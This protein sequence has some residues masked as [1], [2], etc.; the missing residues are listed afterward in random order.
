M[1]AYFSDFNISKEHAL[2]NFYGGILTSINMHLYYYMYVHII[3]QIQLL[4]HSFH[5]YIQGKLSYCHG[6][7]FNSLKTKWRNLTE[8]YT[9]VTKHTIHVFSIEHNISICF[10]K[11][12]TIHFRLN[13]IPRY[14]SQSIVFIYSRVVWK[15]YH[16]K[17]Q[18]YNLLQREQMTCSFWCL[19]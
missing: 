12:L 2:Y 13:H 17:A 6:K 14:W 19:S 9:K 4:F 5:I 3:I 7:S 16:S 11:I 18:C 10:S 8:N 15:E 1:I